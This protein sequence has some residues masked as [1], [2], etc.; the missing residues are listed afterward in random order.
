MIYVFLKGGLS[1]IDTFD[2]KPDAPA[3]FRGEFDPV[4][5]ERARRPDLR[6]CCRSWPSRWTSSSLLRG[7]RHKNSDH[8]PADHYML[9]GYFPQAGFNPNLNPNNQRP[10]LGSIISQQARAARRGQQAAAVPPYVCLPQMHNSGGPAYL[11]RDLRPVR[12]SRPT[13]TPPTSP[14][15]TWRRR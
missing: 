4:A 7:F 9:T 12:R 11:G 13:R 2:M 8:G 15:P 5:D 10:S 3:E 6:A 14:C 1:T